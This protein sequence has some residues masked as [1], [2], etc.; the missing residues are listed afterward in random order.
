M[1][2]AR[3]GLFFILFIL[4]ACQMVVQTDGSVCDHHDCFFNCVA[5]GWFFGLCRGF[6]KSCHCM[7]GLRFAAVNKFAVLN[8]GR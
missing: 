5:D 4:L 8:F 3:F 2:K 6:P 7:A 1:N